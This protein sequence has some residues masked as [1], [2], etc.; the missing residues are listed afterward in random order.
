V[1]WESLG[2]VFECHVGVNLPTGYVSHAQSPQVI[3]I[4]SGFRVYF[5]SRR[6]DVTGQPVSEPLFA[7]FDV[8]WRHR[9]CS[10][11]PVLGQSRL[12]CYDEHGVFPLHVT[13]VGNRV[14]G[15]ISGW[16]R[17]ASVP[18]ETA[19]GLAESY[20]G[21]HTFQRVGYGPILNKSL[22]EPFLVG[23]PCVLAWQSKQYM[24][25]IFGTEWLA[26]TETEPAARVYRIAQRESSDGVNWVSPNHGLVVPVLGEEECQALPSVV[27]WCGEFHMFFCY[28]YATRFRSDSQRGYR[29]GHAVSSDLRNWSRLADPVIPESDWD[30]YMKCYPC[31]F[32]Y[33]NSLYLAYNGNE[34]GRHGFGVAVCRSGF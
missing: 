12:G 10:T 2:M 11:H 23:D 25:Y 30:R 21:G 33:N 27:R 1:I 19:I 22:N 3:K 16:S 29:L 8:D 24:W 14:L 5:S 34:F 20:D 7:E 18:V 6:V 31:A 28:R 15:Y 13:R 4:D 26:A 17:R 32:V 9:L